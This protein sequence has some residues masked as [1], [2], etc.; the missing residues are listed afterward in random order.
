MFARSRFHERDLELIAEP[1]GRVL[2][3]LEQEELLVRDPDHEGGWRFRHEMLRDVA[4]ASLAKRD[5]LRLHLTLAEA[6]EKREDERNIA[7]VA[8]HLEQAAHASLDLNPADRSLADR[9][10]A[11]E[12]LNQLMGRT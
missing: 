7:A 10:V 12:D 1:D 4:Y 11:Y 9:A 8:Y 3:V 5:R 2:E 6:L